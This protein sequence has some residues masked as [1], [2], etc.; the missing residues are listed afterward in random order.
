MR[1][2]RRRGGLRRRRFGFRGRRGFHRR[3][4]RHHMRMAILV[5]FLFPNLCAF[6]CF[7]L[8]LV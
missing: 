3:R 7:P 1:F 5:I 4:V 8:Y 2:R 6:S